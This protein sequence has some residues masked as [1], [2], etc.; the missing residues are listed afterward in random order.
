MVE[1]ENNTVGF[2]HSC[3]AGRWYSLLLGLCGPECYPETR[4]LTLALLSSVISPLFILDVA[5]ALPFVAAWLCVGILV[6]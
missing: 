4:W 3:W 5:P 6:P 2:I 1:V